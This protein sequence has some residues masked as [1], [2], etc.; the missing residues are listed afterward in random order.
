MNYVPVIAEEP[1]RRLAEVIAR[2]VVGGRMR[3]LVGEFDPA[4]FSAMILPALGGYLRSGTRLCWGSTAWP[5][6]SGGV[7]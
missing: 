7:R 4:A 1:M 3:G 5:V 2:S 6:N